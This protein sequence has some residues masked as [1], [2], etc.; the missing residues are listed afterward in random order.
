MLAV[1]PGAAAQVA[2]S[3][4]ASRL[5]S[6]EDRGDQQDAGIVLLATATTTWRRRG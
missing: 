3:T 4:S 2:I 5:L 1:L 6:R